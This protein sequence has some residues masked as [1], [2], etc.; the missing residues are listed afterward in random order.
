MF[1][2]SPYKR[3]LIQHFFLRTWITIG[4]VVKHD[5]QL[6]KPICRYFFMFQALFFFIH[7]APKFIDLMIVF[8]HLTIGFAQ[9][10]K[11]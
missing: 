11:P 1:P 10:G 9:L 3:N 6:I 8:A 2:F 4:N 7:N 5:F